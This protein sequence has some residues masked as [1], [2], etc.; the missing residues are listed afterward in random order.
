MGMIIDTPDE[1]RVGLEARR[2]SFY[3][4]ANEWYGDNAKHLFVFATVDTADDHNS[5]T[6]ELEWDQLDPLIEGLQRLKAYHDKN[7]GKL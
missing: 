7:K 5:A 1:L 2:E 4:V 3:I 6:V